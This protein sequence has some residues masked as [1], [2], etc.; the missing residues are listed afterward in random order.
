MHS[1]E[2]LQQ[3]RALLTPQAAFRVAGCRQRGDLR[4]RP[5]PHK[6]S[7]LYLRHAQPGAGRPAVPGGAK[8]NL[9]AAF[10]STCVEVGQDVPIVW[11]WKVLSPA[12]EKLTT[13]S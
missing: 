3:I 7:F 13:E 11:L 4:G 10:V 8:L 2:S 9:V 12:N 5:E 6:P 1:R